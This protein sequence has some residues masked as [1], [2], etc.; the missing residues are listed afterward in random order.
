[1]NLGVNMNIV[2]NGRSIETRQDLHDLKKLVDAIL[3]FDNLIGV[4]EEPI[5][6][7]R[8]EIPEWIADVLKQSPSSLTTFEIAER[9]QA[10][11]WKTRSKKPV[12]VIRVALNQ[13]KSIFS[14]CEYGWQLR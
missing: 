10:A 7:E 11:G 3:D 12:Q 6:Q 2:I 8:K 1:M 13:N 4:K 5:Q 9:M 14:R